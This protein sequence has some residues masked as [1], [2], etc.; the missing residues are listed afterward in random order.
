MTNISRHLILQNKNINTLFG[1]R[2]S[3]DFR[4]TSFDFEMAP[5]LEL[6]FEIKF[7][8]NS[9]FRLNATKFHNINNL[10]EYFPPL[11][12]TSTQ[13]LMSIIISNAMATIMP[14]NHGSVA[15]FLDDRA[16]N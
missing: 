15:T 3:L 7:K 13:T 4:L 2:Q 5:F 10:P 6:K 1:I 9:N 14:M 16:L 12:L 11:S 8:K